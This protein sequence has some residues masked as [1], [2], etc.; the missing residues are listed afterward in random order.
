MGW[1]QSLTS[2][3]TIHKMHR[4]VD[5]YRISHLTANG[6]TDTQAHTHQHHSHY[7]ET[8]YTRL[9]QYLHTLIG[10]FTVAVAADAAVI[11]YLWLYTVVYWFYHMQTV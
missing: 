2:P 10:G 5:G 4:N 6:Y 1:M 3:R 8:N 11:L 7:A 9:H